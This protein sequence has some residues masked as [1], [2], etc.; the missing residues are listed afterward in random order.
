MKKNGKYYYLV[1]VTNP[2][3]DG[4]SLMVTSS[5]ERDEQD[6]I[7]E[8]VDRDLLEDENDKYCA[9]VDEFVT[10]YDIAHFEKI[11]CIYNLDD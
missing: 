5:F 11:N 10:D 6:I 8:C 9:S 1:C 2:Y 4:Y 7:E 3:I